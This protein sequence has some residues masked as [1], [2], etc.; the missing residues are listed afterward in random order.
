MTFFALGYLLKG[1]LKIFEDLFMSLWFSSNN[2]PFSSLSWAICSSKPEFF[3]S[4]SSHLQ[5]L[6]SLSSPFSLIDCCDPINL[7]SRWSG[8]TLLAWK[9]WDLGSSHTISTYTGFLFTFVSLVSSKKM[10]AIYGTR[11]C[12]SVPKISFGIWARYII[13]I[14]SSQDLSSL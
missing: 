3:S 14:H 6:V 9:S 8:Y 1:D 7:H 5:I 2:L 4:N 13:W 11:V 12:E 10:T